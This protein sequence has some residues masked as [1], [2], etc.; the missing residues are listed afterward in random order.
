MPFLTEFSIDIVPRQYDVNF[1]HGNESDKYR[2]ITPEQAS[3]TLD[4]LD[5]FLRFCNPDDSL[6][7]QLMIE[8]GS[9]GLASL[10]VDYADG[11]VASR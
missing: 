3:P 10:V 8:A 5:A 1:Y 6:Q 7:A 9:D 2:G 11:K 4:N